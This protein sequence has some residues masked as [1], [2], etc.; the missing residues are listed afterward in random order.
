MLYKADWEEAQQR[1]IAWWEGEIIDRVCL[2]V[3]APRVEPW[4]APSSCIP[5][6]AS[7]YQ[8]WTDV[9][10]VVKSTADR[11]RRTFWGGEAFPRFAPNLGPDAFAAFFGAE[12]R[13][14]D[15]QTSWVPPIITDWESAP[16]LKIQPDNRWWQLQLKLLRE[17]K[18]HGDGQ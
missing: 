4:D 16:E 5:E 13:F 9:D 12:L 3:T 10:Y 14:V 11:I 15:P 6:P 1:I 18:A 8:R 2:Q 17:T 7:L